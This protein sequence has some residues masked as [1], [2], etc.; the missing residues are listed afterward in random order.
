MDI[1]K[2][3]KFVEEVCYFLQGRPRL[4]S[5]FL[6]ELSQAQRKDGESGAAAV[7]RVFT[8]Y[9]NSL[10]KEEFS[11]TQS[12][13][14]GF[15]KTNFDQV[16]QSFSNRRQIGNQKLVADLLLKM[17]VK[18]VFSKSR[19]EM[20]FN[21]D[22]SDMVATSLV[23]IK[24]IDGEYCCYMYEPV[25]LH[26]GY[27]YFTN[28]KED[29]LMEYF[30]SLLFEPMETSN[31]SPSERGSLMELAVSVKFMQAWWRN[32]WAKPFIP[33]ELIDYKKP[34][35]IL[36]CRHDKNSESNYFLE[37]LKSYECD[38]LILPS[39]YAG[40]DITYKNI[41]CYLKTR[42]VSNSASSIFVPTTE[43]NK[44]LFTADPDNWYKKNATPY[45][46][47]QKLLQAK[48][49]Y[50]FVHM[51]FELPFTAPSLVGRSNPRTLFIDCR[52]EFSV[53]FFG[54]K[55]V[56]LWKKYSEYA[57]RNVERLEWY[58]PSEKSDAVSLLNK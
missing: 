37:N 25:A 30:A 26:A 48:K 7:S 6:I 58:D 19:E 35:G 32:D 3:S 14:Y 47:C 11:S 29:N 22:E 4:F 36:D 54:E 50:D 40:P 12:S 24:Q 52:S 33:Q 27:N 51:I 45:A 16:L 9:R 57:V 1:F 49:P 44:N 15:W 41:N 21:V 42:W 18:L 55:F 56:D 8:N 53:L 38:S 23:M 2:D 31:Y 20:F 13:L 34:A 5:H 28:T 10:I 17:C 39:T 43:A 46:E